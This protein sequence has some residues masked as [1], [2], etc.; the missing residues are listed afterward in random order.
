MKFEISTFPRREDIR[1]GRSLLQWLIRA[2]SITASDCIARQGGAGPIT[3]FAWARFHS[4]APA[5]A[6]DLV[7]DAARVLEPLARERGWDGAYPNNLVVGLAGPRD[8][9]EDA[10][11]AEATGE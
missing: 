1:C 2:F 10:E 8:A 7:G 3:F 11:S 5:M 4:S 6:R 9:T